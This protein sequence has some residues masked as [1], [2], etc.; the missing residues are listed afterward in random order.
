MAAIAF[1]EAS[2]RRAVKG[3]MDAGFTLAAVEV[4]KNGTIRLL[5]A[6]PQP[7]QSDLRKPEQW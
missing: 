2:I 4:D 1:T 3:A 7:V 5:Q 6:D